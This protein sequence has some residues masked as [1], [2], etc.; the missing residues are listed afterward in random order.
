MSGHLAAWRGT[1]AHARAA[2]AL[3]MLVLVLVLLLVLVL[4]LVLVRVVPRVRLGVVRLGLV[5]ARHPHACA[6]A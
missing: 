3:R 5:H 2:H 1:H 6:T 4:E